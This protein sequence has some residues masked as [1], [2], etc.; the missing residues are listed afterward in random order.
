MKVTAISSQAKNP[1]RVNVSV[2]GKYRLSLDIYQLTE[3]GLRIGKEYGEDELQAFEQ[4]SQFGKLYAQALEYCLMRPHSAREIHDYLWRKARPA[5]YKSRNGEIKERAG[6]SSMITERVYDRLVE[7]GY[8]DDE[9]F[10]TWWVEN[11]NVRK[12]VSQRKL[13]S[14]LRAKGVDGQLIEKIVQNSIRDEKSELLKVINKKRVKYSDDQKLTM[15]LLRQG[16]SYDDI[17]SALQNE[18]D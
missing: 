15:Y 13:M 12:G 5:R 2:D 18:S 4:E 17:R 6:V 11:R 8:V 3:L 1:N 14:E 9:K 16:F 7:K 10:A